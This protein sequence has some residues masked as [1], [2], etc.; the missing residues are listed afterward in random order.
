MKGKYYITKT[1]SNSSAVCELARGCD[2]F[3]IR[4]SERATYLAFCARMR[5]TYGTGKMIMPTK[6]HYSSNILYCWAY[7]SSASNI[8]TVTI[9]GCPREAVS[10][11][12][13]LYKLSN[14]LVIDG[15]TL[16]C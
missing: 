7:R 13:I 16:Q 15:L 5:R 10:N 9:F 8:F 1:A 6:N 14:Q 12:M 11:A 4:F 2:A 3:N